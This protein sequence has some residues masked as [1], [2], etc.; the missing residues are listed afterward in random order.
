[1]QQQGQR[2]PG[3]DTGPPGS[4]GQ[5]SPHGGSEE[6]RPHGGH[7]WLLWVSCGI[8]SQAGGVTAR[9]SQPQRPLRGETRV[10]SRLDCD[11]MFPGTVVVSVGW[12]S[13][14]PQCDVCCLHQ[15]DDALWRFGVLHLATQPGDGWLGKAHL[16]CE[17]G[18][19]LGWGTGPCWVPFGL[20]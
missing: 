16:L 8:G 10:S 9:P 13:G 7:R 18:E 11:G 14:V 1:M 15:R 5:G 6:A 4:R 20:G 2:E 3:G 12:E 17:L 19:K